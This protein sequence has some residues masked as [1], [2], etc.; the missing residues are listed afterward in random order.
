MSSTE[1][2]GERKRKWDE[3]GPAGATVDA[4]SD[5]TAPTDEPAAKQQKTQEATPADGSKEAADAAAEVAARLAAQYAPKKA[6]DGVYVKDQREASDPEF[7]KDI[8]INDLR[9]RYVLTKGAT[10][11]QILADTGANVQSKGLWYPDKT[12]STD[13]DPPLYLHITADSADKLQK[14]I[15]AVQK[16]IDQEL[17]PLLDE[18]RFRRREEREE[19]PER[20]KWTEEKVMID[21]EPLR[22]FNV[23]AKVVGPAGLFVK[24]IQQETGTRVQIKGTGSGFIE[25]DTGREAEDPMHINVTGPDDV[26]IEQ[27]V[28]MAKDLLEVVKEEHAKARAFLEQQWTAQQQGYPPQQGAYGQQGYGGQQP[29]QGGYQQSPYGAGVTA[30]LPPGE[31]PPAPP[32]G[33][34]PPG[35]PPA[36]LSQAPPQGG[37]QQQASAEQWAAYWNSLDPASQAYYTQYYAAYQQGGYSGSPAGGAPQGQATPQPPSGQAPPP[38]PPSAAPPPPPPGGGDEQRGGS[39]RFGAVPPPP[40][41]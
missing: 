26:M 20:R 10:Q 12:M 22:N 35:P 11:Q 37:D 18:R 14:G 38:P 32:S 34:A 41:L 25:T 1:A 2:T 40:G 27:A 17:G 4:T 24:Y 39:G 9:N 33:D 30:P 28:V 13:K 15:D 36:D 7:V 8:E 16:L 31:A 6:T 23:R 29:Y 5:A 3:P 21:V 19:R